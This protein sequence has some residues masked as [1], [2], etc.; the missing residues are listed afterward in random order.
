LFITLPPRWRARA[1]TF[2][3]D[4][5]GSGF[6]AVGQCPCAHDTAAV[7]ET[8]TT[9]FASC[10]STGF[11]EQDRRLAIQN[12]CRPKCRREPLGLGRAW[13]VHQPGTR[14]HPGPPARC[15]DPPWRCMAHTA[16]PKLRPPSWAG[17]S[18]KLRNRA[19]IR[20][21]ARHA[22]FVSC[23]DHDHQLIQIVHGSAAR[24]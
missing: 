17:V 7:G 6:H 13:Q 24:R 10:A 5:Q 4:R 20:P 19:V 8:T 12:V 22:C 21:A 14:F 1:G 23:V 3:D 2:V 11:T 16:A 9:A 18:E 15:G